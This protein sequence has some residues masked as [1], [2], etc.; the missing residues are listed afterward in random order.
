M[1]DYF[2]DFLIQHGT[3]RLVQVM[4]NYLNKTATII[5]S[6]DIGVIC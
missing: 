5:D 2:W 4:V 1:V 6:V 3:I